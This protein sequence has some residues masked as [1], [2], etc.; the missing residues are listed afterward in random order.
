MLHKGFK[1]CLRFGSMSMDRKINSKYN[2]FSIAE[3]L[4][5]LGIVSFLAIGLPAV[6]FKKTE[7]KTQRSQH[8]R[9]ECYYNGGVLTEYMVTEGGSAIGPNAVGTCTF[10]P[11]P[12]A[13]YFF[14]HAVGGG[15]GGVA[16]STSVN[17]ASSSETSTY[18]RN[19]PNL[20]PKWMQDVMSAG[21]LPA[22]ENSDYSTTVSGN[23]ADIVYGSSGQPGQSV[24]MFFPALSNVTISM[25]PGTGGNAGGSGT[26]GSATTVKFNGAEIINATGGAGGSGKGNMRLWID[27]PGALCPIKDLAGRKFKEADFSQNVELD[28]DSAMASKMVEA[29]AGAGG[30][31]SYGNVTSQSSRATYSIDGVDVSASVKRMP[32]TCDNPRAN[33]DSQYAIK[34]ELAG[35]TS[36]TT[37]TVASL[38]QWLNYERDVVCKEVVSRTNV[39]WTFNG[40][41]PTSCSLQPYG[42][43]GVPLCRSN[44]LPRQTEKRKYSCDYYNCCRR[45]TKTTTTTTA[46]PAG[47]DIS[48]SCQAQAGKNGAVV[49]LW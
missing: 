27:G 7:L 15:G 19:S 41:M 1:R 9:Y 40:V 36:T 42:I 4:V 34:C 6:N 48:S 47:S 35:G 22:S 18:R 43:D 14:V 38:S 46:P 25:T 3:M 31:G 33:G 29:Q 20:F 17:M 16:A 2:A 28:T 13:V 30:A 32:G 39:E 26:G 45:A 23:R 24:S 11:P 10:T 12:S 49:I 37:E 21:R 5:V 44:A 8:G